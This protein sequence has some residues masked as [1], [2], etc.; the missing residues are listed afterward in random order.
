MT[1]LTKLREA[2]TDWGWM[3]TLII[4]ALISGGVPLY[5]LI[6]V[7]I[8]AGHEHLHHAVW[9]TLVGGTALAVIA[10]LSK[11]RRDQIFTKNPVTS[12]TDCGTDVYYDHE[13]RS[14]LH[15]QDEKVIG[16]CPH[17]AG[18]VPVQALGK[19]LKRPPR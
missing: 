12:C 7:I 14:W 9:A 19:P 10:I 5:F 18:P 16:S 13:H 2:V 1:R 3:A 8:T 15:Y 6:A 11:R 4:L 17:G